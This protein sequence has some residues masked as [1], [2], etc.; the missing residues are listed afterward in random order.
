M[1]MMA[2]MAKFNINNNAQQCKNSLWLNALI[3]NMNT[4]TRMHGIATSS[5]IVM[6]I[7][8]WMDKM[9]KKEGNLLM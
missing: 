2:E 1:K 6:D 9:G 5:S 4:I 8:G 3:D 7:M